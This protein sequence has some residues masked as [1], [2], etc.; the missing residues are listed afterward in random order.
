MGRERACNRRLPQIC[1][2]HL[3][4]PVACTPASGWERGQVENQAGVV[5]ER[6]FAP[7]IRVRSRDEPSAWLLDRCVAHARAHRHPDVAV[8]A[9]KPGALR[10][11]APFKDWLLP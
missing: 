1:S 2:H 11:G 3:V 10:N 7:R 8:L 4:D 9:R 5:R 6:S